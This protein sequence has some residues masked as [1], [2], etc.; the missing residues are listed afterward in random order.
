MAAAATV[1]AAIVMGIPT[2]LVPSAFYHR[3]TPVTWWDW[4]VW[5]ASAL[6]IG[7]LFATYVRIPGVVGQQKAT[8]VRSLGG[9]L[10]SVFAI[11]CPVCNQIVVAIIG[12]SGALN[13]WAPVQPLLGSFSVALLAAALLFRLRGEFVC[14]L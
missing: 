13:Y 9:S 6:L 4:P 10:L 2:G 1:I 12:V 3:M 14:R 5:V 8:P 11:G 7:L